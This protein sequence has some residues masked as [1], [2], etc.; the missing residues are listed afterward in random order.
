MIIT[1]LKCQIV[2]FN[3]RSREKRTRR[4]DVGF[5]VVIIILAAAGLQSPDSR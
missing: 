3:T 1:T 5:D 2:D 4:T